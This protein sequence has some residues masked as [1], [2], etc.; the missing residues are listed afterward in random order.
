MTGKSMSIFDKFRRLFGAEPSVGAVDAGGMAAGDGMISCEDALRL[1]HEFLDGELEGASA[2]E[3]RQH[4]E[5]CQRCYP[6]LHLETVFREAIQRASLR[7]D[8]PAELKDR[9]SS[10]LAESPADD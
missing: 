10:L 9:V 3:V 7:P 2:D 5:V 8:A 6:H 1:V 4:F